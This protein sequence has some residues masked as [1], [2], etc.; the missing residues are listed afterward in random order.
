MRHVDRHLYTG[1]GNALCLWHRVANPFK[2]LLNT[3]VIYACKLVPSLAL[4][5]AAYRSLGARIGKDVSIGLSVMFDIF[6]PEKIS[7]GDNSIL[8]YNTTVLC[9]EFLIHEWRT[10]EV[11]IGKDVMVGAQSLILPGV[12]IG[13]GATIA[14]YSLVNKD[15]PAGQTWGGVPAKRIR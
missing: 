13:D 11:S 2:T 3:S 8:G 12:T 4:K 1:K 6:F 14:A 5:R 15:V 10:G 9:H 7:I